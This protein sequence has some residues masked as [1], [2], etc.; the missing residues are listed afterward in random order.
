MK[1]KASAPLKSSSSPKK[2]RTLA[3]DIGGS[4]IKAEVLDAAGTP[5]KGRIRVKTPRKS[6]PWKIIA[7]VRGLATEQAGFERI[8]VGFPGVIKEGVV[9][10]AA[11]LGRGWV[12]FDLAQNLRRQLKRPVRVANDAAVQG[13][14][15]ISGRGLELVMTLGTGF[16]SAMFSDGHPIPLELAHHPFHNGKTYE[17]ELGRRALDK[18]G[19]K[20]WNRLLAEAIEDLRRTFNFDQL[21][22]GGGNAKVVTLK[23]PQDTH[24]I[25][26]EAGLLGGIALWRNT[27]RGLNRQK[28]PRTQA[29]RGRRSTDA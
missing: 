15:C 17:D 12:G 19:H 5:L 29:I 8:S 20:K 10:T 24:L 4:G 16:G 27:A 2:P 25:S 1:Q 6:T 28:L 23:L 18:K 3:V 13:L 14:G 11:N 9:Y 26:N 7:A 22:I 21:Y